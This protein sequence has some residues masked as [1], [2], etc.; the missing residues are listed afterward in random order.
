M[1]ER[2][3]IGEYPEYF[4]KYIEKVPKMDL[5]EY[6]DHQGS[7]LFDFILKVS[8]EKLSHSYAEEKWTVAQV[9]SHINDVERIFGY[10]ALAC[11][12]NDK[13]NIPGFEQDDYVANANMINKTKE[14]LANEFQACRNANIA[15]LQSAEK[16]EWLRTCTI[17]GYKTSARAMAYMIA[18]HVE[19]HN[20]IFAEKYF[21]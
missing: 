2:P 14:N 20:R 19:H 1:L 8:D 6:L 9:I 16:S 10:R 4:H 7:K 12:R 5:L 3:Q 21:K 11:L 15:M 17:N 13:G 18:G